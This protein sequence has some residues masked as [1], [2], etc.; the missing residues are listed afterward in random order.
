VS[1][2]APLNSTCYCF[3]I[4]QELSLIQQLD[5]DVSLFGLIF[6]LNTL[7]YT[8][9]LMIDVMLRLCVH[10]GDDVSSFSEHTRVSGIQE[11]LKSLTSC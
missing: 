3:G 2:G 8:L 6:V 7:Q 11:S 1:L 5:Q 4:Y 9:A 10:L